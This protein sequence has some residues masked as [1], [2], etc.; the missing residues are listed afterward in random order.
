M[1]KIPD[2]TMIAV[3]CT[4]RINGTINALVE[5]SENI[6]FGAVKLLSHERPQ[7]LPEFI[8][9]EE[10]PKINNINDYNYFMFLELGKYIQTSHCLTIQDHAKILDYS[11]W[12][13]DWLQFDYGGSPWP[14][15]SNAYMGNDGTRS[16]VGNGGFSIR[17]RRLLN[18]PKKLGLP[19]KQEQNYFNEDGNICCYYKREFL[20][21]GIEYM[22]LTIAIHFAYENTVPENV[23]VKSFGYHRNLPPW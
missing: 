7:N 21:V 2:V 10:C 16:R 15:I 3:D 4:N 14:I 17:S 20:F 19:L 23:G 9:F 8:Q 22:P 12:N 1:L 18:L 6:D 5:C 13:N 11:L